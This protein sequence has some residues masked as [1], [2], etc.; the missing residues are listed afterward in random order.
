MNYNE[1]SYKIRSIQLLT[2]IN[3][4][5]N[6]RLITDPF[7]QR[8]LVWREI[9]KRDFIQTILMG[10]PFPQIFLSK[11]KIDLEKQMS[12]ASVVDGQQ[13]TNAI[14]DFLNNKFP[15]DGKY[16]SDLLD[17]EKEQFYKYEIAIIEL[18]LTHDDP[19]VQEI[20]QRI[21]RTSN[22]LTG[23][24][25]KASEF[26]A[27]EY[28]IVAEFLSE[29]L[30]IDLDKQD[31]DSINDGNSIRENPYINEDMKEW[32]KSVSVKKFNKLITN[33]N[34]F[35]KNEIAKKVNLMYTLNLMTTFLGNEIYNRNQNVW[36]FA[37][38][39]S[40]DFNF[41]DELVIA[42][43]KTAEIFL[44]L[45]LKKSSFWHKKANFFSL[46]LVISKNIDSISHFDINELRVK[47]EDFSPSLEYSLA[48]KEGVNNKK[49]RELRNNEIVN[50]LGLKSY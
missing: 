4:I 31:L 7:F 44:D 34:I 48:A 50:Y 38:N 28:M 20:F 40:N 29:H 14:M 30:T 33:D 19:K 35:T 26:S 8:N 11:G 37:E 47:L 3:D 16:F 25:K 46:F 41:K 1:L 23:I 18:D 22:S 43:E 36:D 9:H 27:S 24:E 13:R 12:I 10:F 49:E 45:K 32:F 42:F 2:Y 5:R 21:N 17:K 15:V 39:Y 6:G